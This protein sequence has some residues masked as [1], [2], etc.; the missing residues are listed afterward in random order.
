MNEEA[1]AANEELE[2]TNEELQTAKEELQS[3]NEELST[4]NEEL[5]GRNA[6]LTRLT[7]DL[8]NL[9]AGVNI[10]VVILDRDFRIRRFTPV[11]ER[12]LHLGP[13]ECGAAGGPCRVETGCDGL[14]PG[15]FAEVMERLHTVEREIQDDQG[16][17]YRLR[18]RAYQTSTTRSMAC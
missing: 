16:H 17:W 10:P 15:S 7:G 2:S 1:L 11:A 12:M 8:S 18:V 14:G 13:E 3:S 5:R 9:L 4:L 6:E